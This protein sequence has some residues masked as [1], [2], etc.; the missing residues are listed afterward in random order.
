MRA[1]SA[2]TAEGCR[3]SSCVRLRTVGAACRR[4]APTCA[5]RSCTAM[6][7]GGQGQQSGTR[8]QPLHDD[9]S[10]KA[11]GHHAQGTPMKQ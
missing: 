3:P 5:I 6:S 2:A 9:N 10:R 7:A 1:A 8:A 4:A 11:Q